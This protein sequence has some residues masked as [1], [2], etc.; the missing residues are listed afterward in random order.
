MM[1]GPKKN[2]ELLIVHGFIIEDNLDD[3]F[4]IGCISDQNN[5]KNYD[6]DQKLCAFPITKYEVSIDVINYL[7]SRR[8][9]EK[10]IRVADEVFDREARE[11]WEILVEYWKAVEIRH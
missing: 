1:Y 4:L 3:Y 6:K 5:C 8:K 9:E 7:L 11:M 10:K 2:L